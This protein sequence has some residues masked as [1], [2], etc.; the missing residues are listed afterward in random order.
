MHFNVLKHSYLMR[1][2]FK[3][4]LHSHTTQV[5]SKSFNSF[6][7]SLDSFSTTIGRYKRQLLPPI[8]GNIDTTLCPQSIHWFLFVH[9]MQYILLSCRLFPPT[10]GAYCSM[11]DGVS[12]HNIL[13]VGPLIFE[14]LTYLQTLDAISPCHPQQHNNIYLHYRKRQ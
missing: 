13:L 12:C 7:S 11:D 3:K 2:F 5:Q 8:D 9:I 1:I 4:Q 6:H 10:S 14:A